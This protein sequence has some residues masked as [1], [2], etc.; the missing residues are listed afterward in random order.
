MDDIPKNTIRSGACGFCMCVIFQAAVWNVTAPSTL[1]CMAQFLLD[2]GCHTDDMFTSYL[3][4]LQLFVSCVLLPPLPW[5]LF[6]RRNLRSG[7]T[8]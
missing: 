8:I 2:G 1:F 6:W 5:V 4:T 3:T 7:K